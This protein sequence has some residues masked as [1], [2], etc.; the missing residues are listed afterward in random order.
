[1]LH[2]SL[3]EWLIIAAGLITILGIA[4]GAILALIL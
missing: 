2:M 3:D 1:M 4:A